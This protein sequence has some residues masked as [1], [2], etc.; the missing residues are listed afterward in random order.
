MD[1]RI[2]DLINN[3]RNLRQITESNPTSANS[4]LPALV[5]SDNYS[6]LIRG[7]ELRVRGL[8]VL[9]DLKEKVLKLEST[10]GEFDSLNSNLMNMKYELSQIAEAVSNHD[11]LSSVPCLTPDIKSIIKSIR[12]DL[13]VNNKKLNSLIESQIGNS[14]RISYVENTNIEYLS[15]LN[16]VDGK[17]STSQDITLPVLT[18]SIE[19]IRSR[20]EVVKNSS[21]DSYN[22]LKEM[23]IKVNIQLSSLT[24]R[25]NTNNADINDNISILTKATF[26]LNSRLDDLPFDQQILSLSNAVAAMLSNVK[27]LSSKSDISNS[28]LIEVRGQFN[29]LRSDLNGFKQM[30]YNEQSDMM[31]QLIG[32]KNQYEKVNS[33]FTSSSRALTETVQRLSSTQNDNEENFNNINIEVNKLKSSI[34]SLNNFTSSTTT[35]M[36]SFTKSLKSLEDTDKQSV[37]DIK[38]LSG[39][40]TMALTDQDS[41]IM[42]LVNTVND[43]QPLNGKLND[44]DVKTNQTSSTLTDFSSK[45]DKQIKSMAKMIES[46]VLNTQNDTSNLLSKINDLE[47]AQ[48][49]INPTLCLLSE[50]VDSLGSSN[51]TLSMIVSGIQSTISDLDIGSIHNAI[52]ILEAKVSSTSNRQESLIS[53]QTSLQSMFQQLKHNFDNDSRFTQ[54]NSEMI[55]LSDMISSITT[56]NVSNNTNIMTLESI[57]SDQS[58]QINTLMG[59]MTSTN[60]KLSEILMRI[61]SMNGTTSSENSVNQKTLQELKNGYQQ[62]LNLIG[63]FNSKLPIINKLDDD[64]GTLSQRVTSLETNSNSGQSGSSLISTELIAQVQSLLNNETIMSKQIQSQ[65]LS[66]QDIKSQLSSIGNSSSGSQTDPS[67]SIKISQLNDSINSLMNS[68]SQLS[69]KVVNQSSQITSIQSDLESLNL[70]STT[71]LLN[72]L[73]KL[74]SDLESLTNGSMKILPDYNVLTNQSDSNCTSVKDVNTFASLIIGNAVILLKGLKASG[75]ISS[76]SM[77]IGGS[78]PNKKGTYTLD[79]KGDTRIDGNIN[80]T[81]IEDLGRLP[82]L[83]KVIDVRSGTVSSF[84]YSGSAPNRIKVMLDGIFE[85]PLSK[86]NGYLYSF[87]GDKINIYPGST[88]IGT[89]FNSV[90][91][92]TSPTTGSYH[93]SLY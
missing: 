65:G 63:V 91:T 62:L 86:D 92:T 40:T 66:L 53:S 73:E 88:S 45:T 71:G 44:L 30:S 78:I 69:S 42:S 74:K 23:I 49:S 21:Q 52:S 6:E 81:Y 4:I 90:G 5:V 15:K 43:L 9:L 41:K 8:E 14:T 7:I 36:S 64:Y 28:G 31:S 19:K 51:N 87:L 11:D 24:E 27:E 79:I 56:T 48:N 17:L 77:S 60:S 75:Q 10:V 93:V 2:K 72:S 58:N 83:T 39:T 32:V 85:V 57:S 37:D 84:S 12:D 26:E 13:D 54:I 33:D 80:G 16:L 38:K 70:T 20:L 82:K 50:K 25:A 29:M 3:Q 47:T 89:S 22:S 68:N 67:L 76:D 55:S 34:N 18:D 35:M 1:Q 46:L 59:F 61:N